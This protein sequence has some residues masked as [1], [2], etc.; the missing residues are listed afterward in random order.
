MILRDL[1]KNYKKKPLIEFQCISMKAVEIRS[2]NWNS[3]SLKKMA[4][5]GTKISQNLALFTICVPF[6]FWHAGPPTFYRSID[7]P[8]SIDAFGSS[9]ESIES[10]NRVQDWLRLITRCYFVVIVRMLRYVRLGCVETK[11]TSSMSNF[12]CGDERGIFEKKNF[13]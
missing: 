8:H 9:I 13:I 1:S 11:N 3:L 12:I 4:R 2:Q 7:D 6:F 10:G 5:N